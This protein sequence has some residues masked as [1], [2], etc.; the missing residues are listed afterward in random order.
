[1]RKRKGVGARLDTCEGKEVRHHVRSKLDERHTE[2]QRKERSL[3]EKAICE[4]NGGMESKLE[5]EGRG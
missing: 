5:T 2:M 3:C 4:P 1:M